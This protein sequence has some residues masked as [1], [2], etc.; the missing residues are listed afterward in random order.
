PE[1]P[2]KRR[3]IRKVLVALEGVD[4]ARHLISYVL[5]QLAGVREV[6]VAFRFHPVLP[7]EYFERKYGFSFSANAN[8]SVS[9]GSLAQAI[10]SADVLV[11]CS[12]TVSLEALMVGKPVVHFHGGVLLSLD[13]LFACPHHK[14]VVTRD[15]SLIDVFRQIDDLSDTAFRNGQDQARAYIRRYFE[16]VR[17]EVVERFFSA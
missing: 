3:A 16:P 9:S 1:S 11:Y 17:D 14:W 6:E 4:E 10:E 5:E 12:T 15:K 7:A 13:P 2:C 8:V